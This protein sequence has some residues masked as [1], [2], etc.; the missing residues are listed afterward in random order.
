M[1][2]ND[3]GTPMAG[4]WVEDVGWVPAAPAAG[5]TYRA[6][7]PGDG[8]QNGYMGGRSLQYAPNDG[9]ADW[10]YV[11]GFDPYA[12]RTDK[13]KVPELSDFYNAWNKTHVD[14]YGFSYNRPWNK[15]GES[16][17]RDKF[18]KEYTDAIAEYNQIH[19]TNLKPDAQALE[20][21]GAAPT[22][23]AAED[24][25][26][27]K[28]S[29]GFFSGGLG[30]LVLVGASMF[31]APYLSGLL[32]GGLAGAV[33][34]GAIIGGG[35]AALTGGNVLKGALLGG[36][37]GGIGYGFSGGGVSG[38]E[39]SPAGAESWADWGT[40]GP[41]WTSGGDLPVG[42]YTGGFGI[43]DG[44]AGGADMW[45]DWAGSAGAGAPDL[46]TAD[47]VSGGDL[48]TGGYTGGSGLPTTAT[49]GG[50]ATAAG[51][52]TGG[53]TGGTAAGG[54]TT[55]GAA[56][57]GLTGNATVDT[58]LKGLSAA[59][60]PQALMGTI[61]SNLV[62]NGLFG[63][64][65]ARDAAERYSNAAAAALGAN[66]AITQEQ[67]ARWKQQYAP[68]EDELIAQARR[69][70]GNEEIDSVMGRINADATQQFGQA[71]ENLSEELRRRGI[72]PGSGA[73]IL[74]L[75]ELGAAEA[76]SKNGAQT[77]AKE[78]MR[79]FNRQFATNIAGLG[80]GIPTRTMSS[81]G[82]ITGQNASLANSQTQL[83]MRQQYAAGQAT[84]PFVRAAN[85]WFN[86][87]LFKGS[88]GL[89][90]TGAAPAADRFGSWNNL[91]FGSGG[92][93]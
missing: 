38:L 4:R 69:G 48:P 22:Q 63:A 70:L 55:G 34:S 83:G 20:K 67:Y 35:G 1:Q 29:S 76:A 46:A 92:Y 41:G 53:T 86:N 79:Q 40:S 36:L 13:S 78:G 27:R 72:Q 57:G 15:H 5:P 58:V 56:T 77:T 60:V 51:G 91:E 82:S 23:F 8:D 24:W 66:Q 19:G 59:G 31:G 52:T 89:P 50:G 47:W 12:Y 44:A 16:A 74:G 3:D 6:W 42:G 73:E 71:R 26:E 49:A 43:P 87:N 88:A 14:Q 80:R 25:S 68:L 7:Q 75:S 85:D 62:A 33:G 54:A 45:S 18:V 17:L 32:G 93:A 21:F 65:D 10:T 37:G 11:E 90:G 30:Q 81:L 9:G 39:G 64:D 61:V 28:G 84:A 2:Y